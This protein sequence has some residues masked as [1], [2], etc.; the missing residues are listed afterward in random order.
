MLC[1]IGEAQPAKMVQ[2]LLAGHM[3]TTLVLFYQALAFGTRLGICLH[4]Y[5]ILAIIALLFYPDTHHRTSRWQMVLVFTSKAVG[6]STLAVHCVFYCINCFF[7]QIIAAFVRTPLD[8]L[9]VVGHLPTMPTQILFS[10]VLSVFMFLVREVLEKK[11]MGDHHIAPG[12]WT[13]SKNAIG[14][15]VFNL[16]NQK[17]F[18]THSIELMPTNEL[19]RLRVLF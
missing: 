6:V 11:A 5:D 3:H 17:I 12:L 19:V 1:P 9:V 13:P 4:P 16:V 14:P 7:G 10:I 18:P 15:H 8:I 2:T